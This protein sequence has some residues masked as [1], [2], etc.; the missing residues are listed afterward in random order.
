MPFRLNFANV[1]WM[2]QFNYPVIARLKPGITLDQAKAELD[3]LQRSVAEIASRETHEPVVLRGWI[4]PPEESIVGRARLGLL[5][6]LGAIGGVV[7]IACANL[8]NLSLTRAAGRLRDAAVRSA[9]GASRGRLVAGV[10][11]EQLVLALIGGALGLLVAR[12]CLTLFVGTAPIDLPRVN[13][14]A[15]DARV[16]LSQPP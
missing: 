13:A 1:G 14:V 7:L 5:F 2:G 8:A 16:L 15:I 11:L 12:E 3:F 6:L 10:V 4:K 9:L